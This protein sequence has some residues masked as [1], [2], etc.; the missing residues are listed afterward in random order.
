MTK[1]LTRELIAEQAIV[2]EAAALRLPHTVDRNFELPTGLY[3]TMAALFFAAAGVMAFGFAAP[4]MVVPTGIIAVFIAMFFAVPAMWVRMKPDHPQRATS[5]WRFQ[6]DGIMTLYGHS[7][8]GAATVQVLIQS[9]REAKAKV[10]SAKTDAAGKYTVALPPGHAWCWDLL[11]PAGYSPVK[12]YDKDFF[13]TTAK[14]PAYRKDFQVRKGSAWKVIVQAPAGAPPLPKT[15]VSGGKQIPNEYLSSYI[16]LEGQPQG[17]LHRFTTCDHVVAVDADARDAI[18]RAALVQVGLTGGFLHGGAHAEP[19]VDDDEHDRQLPDRR[20]VQRLVPRA[21]VG[22]RVAELTDDRFGLGPTGPAVGDRQRRAGGRWDLTA[23]DGVA[24]EQPLLDVE[25]VHRAAP[26]MGDARG[27]AEQFGHYPVRRNATGD[28]VPVL[29]VG[30]E[31]VVA[32][33]HGVH[34]ADDGGLLAEI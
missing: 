6:R 22:G 31:Q 34:Q 8:A 17:V 18:R 4:M 28:G 23:D 10:R 21:D 1:Q 30:G 20:D 3:A 14:E 32:W 24:P 27:A 9:E 2:T 29:A 12:S 15:Y 7:T 26:A 5:W 33:L 19:V 25:Q 16:V 11:P 13:A